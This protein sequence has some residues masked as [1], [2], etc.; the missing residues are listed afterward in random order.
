MDDIE[1]MDAIRQLT[2]MAG[3]PI[4]KDFLEDK[5]KY[6]KGRLMDCKLEEITEH[7]AYVKAYESVFSYVQE[8]IAK[9]K[10][11]LESK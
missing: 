7:R 11:A 5:I 10:E 3:W 2:E 4:I 1:R 6:R 8:V 9:G